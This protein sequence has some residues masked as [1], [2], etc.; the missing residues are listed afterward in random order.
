MINPKPLDQKIIDDIAKLSALA[1]HLEYRD[2]D[3]R[4][5]ELNQLIKDCGHS[6]P[7]A[8]LFHNELYYDRDGPLLVIHMGHHRDW[9]PD[10]VEL[11]QDIFYVGLDNNNNY[12]GWF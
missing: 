1:Y 9:G 7:S 10:G 4:N 12:Q 2:Q 5:N 8:I 6:Y 3:S 11:V